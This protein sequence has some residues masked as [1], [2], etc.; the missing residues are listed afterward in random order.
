M[1]FSPSPPG[2]GVGVKIPFSFMLQVSTHLN[3][4]YIYSTDIYKENLPIP[5][6]FAQF[7]VR[8]LTPPPWGVKITIFVIAPGCNAQSFHPFRHVFRYVFIRDSHHSRAPAPISPSL[9]DMD[10]FQ[11]IFYSHSW[12]VYFY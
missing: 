7:F 3:I 10:G 4:I 12:Y 2:W 5:G 9:G 1:G 6:L 11:S 8:F